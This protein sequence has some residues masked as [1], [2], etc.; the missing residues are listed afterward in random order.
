MVSAEE[1][2][3]LL[4]D[5]NRRY[6]TCSCEF[7][8]LFY[9]EIAAR[10]ERQQVEAGEVALVDLDPEELFG[11][12]DRGEIAGKVTKS[13]AMVWVNG[14]HCY[15]EQDFD[16]DDP[17]LL[18]RDATTWW[19]RDGADPPSSG[20]SEDG[21]Q[22]A[23]A[24][25]RYEMCITPEPL[26]ARLDFQVLGNG[27][28]AG[29]EVIRTRARRLPIPAPVSSTSRI[30]GINL[31]H[32]FDLPVFSNGG[33]DFTVEI[34]AVT[35]VLLRIASVFEN[36]DWMAIEAVKAEFDKPLPESTFTIPPSETGA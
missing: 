19:R 23:A 33:D 8:V 25:G 32:W 1:L 31:N 4:C 11:E 17:Q 26:T 36:Q 7:A 28:R 5:A 14:P 20:N 6:S 18:V 13:R 29:R 12:L 2:R 22:P 21:E 3:R 16:K 10:A 35:G 9:P 24:I 30:V 34:D 27:Q 15:R